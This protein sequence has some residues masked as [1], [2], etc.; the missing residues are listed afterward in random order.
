MTLEQLISMFAGQSVRIIDDGP[1][2]GSS[3]GGVCKTVHSVPDTS[4]L[5]ELEME[6]GI[7]V[8]F[9]PEVVRSYYIDGELRAPA[10]G[11]RKIELC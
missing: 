6:D 4:D 3:D 10:K 5:F 9:V 1:R 2:F 11:R 7:R 8:E